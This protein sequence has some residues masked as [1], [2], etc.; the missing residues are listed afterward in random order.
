MRLAKGKATNGIN[1]KLLDPNATFNAEAEKTPE[2]M[3]TLANNIL[4]TIAKLDKK[5]D[6]YYNVPVENSL[7]IEFDKNISS[8]SN[9]YTLYDVNNVNNDFVVSKLDIKYLDDGLK[10]AKSSKY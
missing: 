2:K 4:D 9:P 1:L 8:F 7:A 6:F 3:C 10:I 5:H